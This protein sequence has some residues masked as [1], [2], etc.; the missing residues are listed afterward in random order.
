MSSSAALELRNALVKATGVT[1]TPVIVV[2]RPTPRS[3]VRH[4]LEGLSAE[5]PAGPYA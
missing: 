3:L 5:V 2:D 4:L 1:L